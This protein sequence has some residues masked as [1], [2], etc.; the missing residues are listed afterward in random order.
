MTAKPITPTAIDRLK[1]GEKARD[2]TPGLYAERNANGSVSWRYLRKDKAGKHVKQTLGSTASFTIP[3]AREW[4]GSFNA[5]IERGHNPVAVQREDEAATAA[6]EKRKATTFRKVWEHYIDTITPH[7]S[8]QTIRNKRCRM[9][10]D[11]LPLIGDKPI[12]E[13]TLDD[14]WS[15]NETK[16]AA[17]RES[18]RFQSA[19][20]HIVTDLKSFFKWC[21]SHGR[22]IAGLNG[23]DPA[24]HLKKLGDEGER[25]RFVDVWELPLLVRAMAAMPAPDRRLLTLLL[26]T[27]QRLDNVLSAEFDQWEAEI[28]S[29]V[30]MKMK[31]KK[32]ERVPNVLPLSPWGA[33]LFVRP[34]VEQPWR[35]PS[36]AH[37]AEAAEKR[38]ARYL[39]PATRGDGPRKGHMT[40]LCDS[41]VQRMQAMA[42]AGKT[43]ERIIPHDFR[44]TM[45]SHMARLK[46]PKEHRHAI[47]GHREGGIDKHYMMYEFMDEKAA[48]LAAWENEIIRIALKEGVADKLA[49]PKAEPVALTLV[50]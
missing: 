27:G 10:N 33:S 12:S 50:A 4:A 29:W 5:L 44:R 48:G 28:S 11:V 15:V 37:V 46:V 34:V 21:Q 8:E 17:G 23:V 13:V 9:T 42:P 38:V 22:H 18:G 47:A 14:L 31:G 45:K 3:E 2:T 40:A 25:T 26:L 6:E 20:N 1:V 19:A 32:R 24:E 36:R 16:L 49:I 41:L 30:I 39:F 43:V 35:C 7:Q